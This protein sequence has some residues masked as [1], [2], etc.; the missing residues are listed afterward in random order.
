[1][2]DMDLS[3][4]VEIASWGRVNTCIL[5]VS[6]MFL[7]ISVFLLCSLSITSVLSGL[8]KK[9]YNNTTLASSSY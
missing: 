3:F 4:C 6:V 9:K 1:M 8:V 5:S 2:I 7:H